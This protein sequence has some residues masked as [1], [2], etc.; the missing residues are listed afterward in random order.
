MRPRILPEI[1]WHL[2]QGGHDGRLAGHALRL[3][4]ETVEL[5]IATGASFDEINGRIKM[6]LDKAV[7]KGHHLRAPHESIEEEI[8]DVLILLNV[9]A[10]HADVDDIRTLVHDKLKILRDRKWVVDDD[11]VL[12]RPK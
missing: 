4:N 10:Y 3:L 1:K 6:E 5:C 2:E 11:G 8:A 12:W 7:M 9:L